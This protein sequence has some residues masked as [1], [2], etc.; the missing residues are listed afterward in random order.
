MLEV[1]EI[2]EFIEEFEETSEEFGVEIVGSLTKSENRN[3]V[4][5]E[6]WEESL[7]FDIDEGIDADG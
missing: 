4:S 1:I 5:F 2:E 3:G 6:S 7:V